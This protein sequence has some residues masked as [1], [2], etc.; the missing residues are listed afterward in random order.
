[1]T[2]DEGRSSEKT[3]LC[4]TARRKRSALGRASK[5]V[6]SKTVVEGNKTIEDQDDV[7][8]ET[9][10]SKQVW[11]LKQPR[12]DYQDKSDL[13]TMMLMQSILPPMRSYLPQFQSAEQLANWVFNVAKYRS[14]KLN[15]N[16]YERS[17]EVRDALLRQF[18][19]WPGT[20]VSQATERCQQL[21][22]EAE[23]Q[24][25][26]HVQL[27]LHELRGK[28]LAGAK[29]LFWLDLLQ[30]LIHPA[31]VPR[32]EVRDV[33]TA[34][35]DELKGVDGLYEQLIEKNGRLWAVLTLPLKL[36]PLFQGVSTLAL[37]GHQIAANEAMQLLAM[38][39]SEYP[40]LARGEKCKFPV[41]IS[42]VASVGDFSPLD[43]SSLSDLPEM[44]REQLSAP[45]VMI[46]SDWIGVVD[47]VLDR[48]KNSLTNKW[49]SCEQAPFG[50]ELEKTMESELQSAFQRLSHALATD[51]LYA[52][53]KV[54]GDG[55][56]IDMDCL[57]VNIVREQGL[58]FVTPE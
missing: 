28:L 21:S 9:C 36:E 19:R 48:L 57:N 11:K 4:M 40:A 46:V 42:I 38:F 5:R 55:S 12:Y 29:A 1:M 13:K 47:E 26:E 35:L 25:Q 41:G 20:K 39:A 15:L 14:M 50:E 45:L 37:C 49:T 8:M 24:C 2:W 56:S 34:F 17:E 53:R 22:Q 6:K 44:F 30:P 3:R 51:Q 27:Y 54:A 7:I 32:P 23:Q 33:L 58:L 18:H 52:M 16:C 43:L 31:S 10:R